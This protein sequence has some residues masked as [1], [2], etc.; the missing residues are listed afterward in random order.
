MTILRIPRHRL[1]GDGK[2]RRIRVV[3]Q[4][5]QPVRHDPP[6]E[7]EA[8]LEPAALRFLAAVDEAIQ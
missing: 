5:E 4:L 2:A 6:A 7:P 8:I 3:G 1:G